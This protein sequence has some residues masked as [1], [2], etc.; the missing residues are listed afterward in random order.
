MEKYNYR[1]FSCKKKTPHIVNNVSLKRGYK[2]SCL[3]C[4]EV[5]KNYSRADL[6]EKIEE[7]F[8]GG[9]IYGT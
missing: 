3:K 8:K 9:A 2:L 5:A 1:C 4:G 7:E 6:L